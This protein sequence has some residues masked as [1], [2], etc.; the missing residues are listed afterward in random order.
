MHDDYH[1]TSDTVDKVNLDYFERMA[2]FVYLTMWQV[3]DRPPLAPA[4]M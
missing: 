3:A 2:R 1:R 4:A